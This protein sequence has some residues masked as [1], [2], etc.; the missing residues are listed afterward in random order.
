V[1][2]QYAMHI[3]L[4]RRAVSGHRCTKL[5]EKPPYDEMSDLT[6][7][8][9]Q[10]EPGGPPTS[11]GIAKVEPVGR[12]WLVRRILACA[13]WAATSLT[14]AERFKEG[15]GSVSEVPCMLDGIL[16]S[17]VADTEEEGDPREWS[18]NLAREDYNACDR[19]GDVA[20]IRGRIGKLRYLFMEA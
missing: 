8:G 1:T 10:E 6:C 11:E 13:R 18:D 17:T 15:N 2:P 5:F 16:T 14:L 19:D 7:Q 9:P 3:L 12:F 4:V 20:K